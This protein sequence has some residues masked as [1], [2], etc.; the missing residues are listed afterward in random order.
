MSF[1][2]DFIKEKKVPDKDGF[3]KER[4]KTKEQKIIKRKRAA[5]RGDKSLNKDEIC[6]Y[7]AQYILENKDIFTLDWLRGQKLTFES[8]CEMRKKR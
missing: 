3:K 5:V 8:V 1:W 7:L 6:N 4:I 2:D